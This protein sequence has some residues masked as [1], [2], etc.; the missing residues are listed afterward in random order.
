MHIV[1]SSQPAEDTSEPLRCVVVKSP[2]FGL[3]ELPLGRQGRLFALAFLE[4][5]PCIV[6]PLAFEFEG[7][8][9]TRSRFSCSDLCFLEY[10]GIFRPTRHTC[11]SAQQVQLHI[12]REE[13]FFLSRGHLA[14][15][16][17]PPLK[18]KKNERQ[19]R[20]G[21]LSSFCFDCGNNQKNQFM[22]QVKLLKL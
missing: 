11:A 4:G 7:R 5:Q 19:D 16:F 20:G 3:A 9:P 6:P 1:A 12:G 15:L 10:R 8:L 22:A 14:L 2:R 13:G 17:W 21:C 18:E